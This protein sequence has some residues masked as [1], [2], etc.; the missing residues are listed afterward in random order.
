M[1]QISF[2]SLALK[3]CNTRYEIEQVDSELQD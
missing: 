2:V 3:T 1:K